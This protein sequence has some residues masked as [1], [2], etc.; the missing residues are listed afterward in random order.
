MKKVSEY[1]HVYAWPVDEMPGIIKVSDEILLVY[2]KD[3]IHV[4]AMPNT[5]L[6]DVLKTLQ[7]HFP[8]LGYLPL[9]FMADGNP[10]PPETEEDKTD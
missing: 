5:K 6:I 1:A 7:E 9:E 4:F 2:Q 3:L 8:R 10:T